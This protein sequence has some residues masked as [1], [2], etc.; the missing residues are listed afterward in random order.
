MTAFFSRDKTSIPPGEAASSRLLWLDCARGIAVVLM[1]IYHLS[2]DLSFHHFI[3]AKVNQ[4]LGWRIFARGIAAS[5]LMLAGYSLWLAHG[6]GFKADKFWRREG[7]LIAAAA[8]VT[9]GTWY[10]FPDS[11]VFFGI[12]HAIA[13]SS[14]IG[15]I[16]LRLPVL[17]TLLAAAAAL[18]A[19]FFLAAPAFD[20][21]LLAF[22]GLRTY[23]PTTN[24]Y[25]PLL[26]WV[27]PLLLG[28]ALGRLVPSLAIRRSIAPDLGAIGRGLRFLGRHSLLIY[29]LHQP[30]LF[31]ATTL[32]AGYFKPAINDAE[33]DF[34]SGCEAS[35]VKQGTPRATCIE[36]CFCTVDGLKA[37]GAF[38]SIAAGARD[39]ATI[40]AIGQMSRTCQR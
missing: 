38:K 10:A 3:E 26:P 29:L 28:I 32:A 14:L 34:L 9:A 19:P 35:C 6:R 31:G 16:F 17:V 24:D 2:W 12:L 8:L 39:K 37:T 13:A 23:P 15:L 4:E 11:Y 25:V 36:I 1:V 27:S 5:F 33:G 7:I 18:A 40:D 30:I 22:I 20:A 21:P